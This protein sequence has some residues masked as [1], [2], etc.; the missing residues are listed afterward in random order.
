[1]KPMTKGDRKRVLVVDDEP[2]VRDLLGVILGGQGLRVDLAASGPEALTLFRENNYDFLTL[3]LK[4]P[5][6]DGL[7][8]HRHLTRLYGYGRRQPLALPQFL[9]P[10]VVITAYAGE[11]LDPEW[12]SGEHVVAVLGKPLDVGELLTVVASLLANADQRR[13]RREKA[14]SRLREHVIRP[15]QHGRDLPIKDLPQR[16]QRTQRTD[17]TTGL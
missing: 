13:E 8:L 10:I 12:L 17:E 6:M 4:M 15:V 1:M 16:T 7:A 5:C 14:L 11:D 2:E 3:D 9:P